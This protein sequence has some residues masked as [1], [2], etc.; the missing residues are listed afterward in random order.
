MKRIVLLA[1]DGTETI[2]DR[3][4]TFPEMQAMVGGYVEHVRILRAD[5]PGF[6]YT[7][8]FVNEEGLR[9]GLPRNARATDLYL[10][11]VRRQFPGAADPYAEA[12]DA[13]KRRAAA[14]GAFFVST[15]SEDYEPGILGPAV[16][17]DGYTEREVNILLD[18]QEVQ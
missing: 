12:T 7:S 3:P 1:P 14:M 16:W 17:F 2:L 15:V 13:M 9:L 11:N 6:T 10:A 18:E 8:M 4:P 5:L